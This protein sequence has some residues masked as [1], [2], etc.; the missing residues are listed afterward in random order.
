ML[1]NFK[2]SHI[3]PSST[4]VTITDGQTLLS[5][6]NGTVDE[7]AW[8]TMI[9]PGDAPVYSP[10]TEYP[11]KVEPKMEH[12][13]KHYGSGLP[14]KGSFY[15]RMQTFT[16]IE[17]M[18]PDFLFDD[19]DIV[20]AAH[21][22]ERILSYC[23]GENFHGK[24]GETDFRLNL[25]LAGEKTLFAERRRPNSGPEARVFRTVREWVPDLAA[26]NNPDNP[27]FYQRFRTALGK[28]FE[29]TFTRKPLRHH[30]V[31]ERL[32]DHQ[33]FVLYRLGHLKV[34][35]ETGVDARFAMPLTPGSNDSGDRDHSHYEMST[36]KPGS[37]L[38]YQTV[39]YFSRVEMS[40]QPFP[41]SQALELKI[42]GR[43]KESDRTFVPAG[44]IVQCWFSRVPHMAY[45]MIPKGDIVLKAI[46][47]VKM[48]DACRELEKDARAQKALRQTVMLLDHLR[49][50]VR[51]AS[52]SATREKDRTASLVIGN[53]FVD[54][55]IK[56][57]F[58]HK[59]HA[60][61]FGDSFLKRWWVSQRP[62]GVEF[63]RR[64][65][66]RLEYGDSGGRAKVVEK[67][68]RWNPSTAAAAF[69]GQRE[70]V[71]GADPE[72]EPAVTIDS[73]LHAEDGH[74]PG[75]GWALRH[76]QPKALVEEGVARQKTDARAAAEES[77]ARQEMQAR[78]AARIKD[79]QE[80]R[81]AIEATLKAFSRIATQGAN[82]QFKTES[83]VTVQ[84]EKG[85]PPENFTPWA[86]R[87]DVVGAKKDPGTP[88]V[89]PK[90][91]STTPGHAIP[92]SPPA[93]ETASVSPSSE[94]FGRER[95][96]AAETV[97][98]ASS[99]TRAPASDQ[100][101]PP[102]TATSGG[103]EHDER[104]KKLARLLQVSRV[105][106]IKS[107]VPGS[108]ELKAEKKI[109][110]E[111]E[112]K[113]EV[114]VEEEGDSKT[115]E[116][117]VQ[118]KEKV[119]VQTKKVEAQPNEKAE[120]Q[121]EKVEAQ[122]KTVEVRAKKVE[123]QIKEKA[124]ADSEGKAEVHTSEEIEVRTQEKVEVQIKDKVEKKARETAHIKRQA[125]PATPAAES[126]TPGV[127]RQ[128][129]PPPKPDP[130]PNR[131]KPPA[132]PPKSS[133]GTYFIPTDLDWPE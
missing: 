65:R 80:E 41:H 109:V 104:A 73:P 94:D 68:L 78:A 12:T 55:D 89:G 45:G 116:V 61:P 115:E 11:V 13:I 32:S 117:K 21:T 7:R 69:I 130:G 23:Y 92:R 26:S 97:G 10:P 2:L 44:D 99:R 123:V 1:G 122:T 42:T 108:V 30:S 86:A 133:T 37:W 47:M 28:T 46:R 54:P 22:L 132:V 50:L 127:K 79:F 43:L 93:A 24:E 18:R 63:C 36:A 91:G 48:D 56:V 14:N 121:T 101:K 113:A 35:V 74:R 64:E 16:S 53:S 60:T 52:R 33:R 51:N 70:E 39:P 67:L 17:V 106:T 119:E 8:H 124:A 120:V 27:E 31:R 100:S 58:P 110:K 66:V 84:S 72:S 95:S 20:I 19:V 6:W 59:Q 87:A 85:F 107:K 3:K 102:A 114:R 88:A 98:E 83:S 81:R 57:V 90:M 129:K 128:P 105:G 9:V 126:F 75:E 4:H 25:A 125:R 34:V 40:G 5:S 29:Q 103:D 76:R 82:P 15:K 77:D 62:G 111:V 112:E 118:V 71:A 131:L 38:Q 96:E 49:D